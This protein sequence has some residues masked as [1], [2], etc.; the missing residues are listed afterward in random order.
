M[1]L[2]ITGYAALLMLAS[3]TQPAEAA[4]TIKFTACQIETGGRMCGIDVSGDIDSGEAIELEQALTG[5]TGSVV[6]LS[7]PGGSLADGMAMGRAMRRANATAYVDH[8][9]ASA[10]ALAAL[11]A[12]DTVVLGDGLLILHS[13]FVPG[14]PGH[15]DG[16]AAAL[17]GAYLAEIGFAPASIALLIGH[18]PSE[19]SIITPGS[20]CGTTPRCWDIKRKTIA[21][22]AAPAAPAQTGR[23]AAGMSPAPASDTAV[24][25]LCQPSSGGKPYHVYYHGAPELR[26]WTDGGPAGTYA[27]EQHGVVGNAVTVT[28]VSRRTGQQIA[29]SYDARGATLYGAY[30]TDRCQYLK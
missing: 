20:G 24:H 23:S 14:D 10:C 6:H 16:G 30:G 9:C 1:K 11:G 3:A 22:S 7:G 12:A 18:D 15:A 28:A 27:I 17:E 4:H 29:V 19:I 21:A 8:V 5:T 2:N 13:A 25:L 26:T